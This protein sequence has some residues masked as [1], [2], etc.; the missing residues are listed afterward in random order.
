MNLIVKIRQPYAR[1]TRVAAACGRGSRKRRPG[2]Q[3][4]DGGKKF[5]NGGHEPGFTHWYLNR[6]TG[7]LAGHR[8]LEAARDHTTQNLARGSRPAADVRRP[9]RRNKRDKHSPVRWA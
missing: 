4:A 5:L 6:K 2:K 1:V 9:R 8:Q 7:E 3:S